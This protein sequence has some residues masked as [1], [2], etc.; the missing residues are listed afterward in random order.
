MQHN[1]SISKGIVCCWQAL[2]AT[3]ARINEIL[4]MGVPIPERVNKTVVSRK[5]REKEEKEHEHDAPA[6]PEFD[7][8]TGRRK[9]LPFT[10]PLELRQ[11]LNPLPVEDDGHDAPAPWEVSQIPLPQLLL[12]SASIQAGSR[13]RCM[14]GLTDMLLKI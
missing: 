10:L 13:Y 11:K 6:E 14:I 5:E 4:N 1:D 9:I 3:H 12:V 8:F 7:S 2:D